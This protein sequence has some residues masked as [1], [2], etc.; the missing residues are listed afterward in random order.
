MQ[1][2]PNSASHGSQQRYNHGSNAGR[3]CQEQRGW[4]QA[5]A[6]S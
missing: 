4:R 6:V 2:A 3:G 5:F 1:Q